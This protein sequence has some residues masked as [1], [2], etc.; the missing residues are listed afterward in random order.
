MKIK[1]IVQSHSIEFRE[2][3]KITELQKEVAYL[4]EL[5]NLKR[6]G[7]T[8][9]VHRQLYM[10]KKENSKLKQIASVNHLVNPNTGNLKSISLLKIF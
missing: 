8:E 1:A 5:L 10:L 4:K 9:D 3:E 2:S 7:N 6:S